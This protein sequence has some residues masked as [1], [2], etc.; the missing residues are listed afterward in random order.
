MEQGDV[1]YIYGI[2][3][4]GDAN[5]ER[6]NFSIYTHV[7]KYN[8]WIKEKIGTIVLP[9]SDE[10]KLKPLQRGGRLRIISPPAAKA[11]KNGKIPP[12]CCENGS[13]SKYC[14]EN[15]SSSPY[16]CENNS[17]SPYCCENGSMNEDCS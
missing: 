8:G 9:S 7:N 2:V 4:A 13:Q 12:Y 17:M 5:C 14:C 16:C 1:W 6:N 11:C 15:G 10:G 3:S